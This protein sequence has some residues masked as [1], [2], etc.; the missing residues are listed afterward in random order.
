[1]C[2]YICLCTYL[3]H[4]SIHMSIHMSMRMS[5]HMS[6]H[7]SMR[8]SVHMSIHMSIHMSVHMSVHMS[9]HMCHAIAPDISEDEHCGIDLETVGRAVSITSMDTHAP[10][11]CLRTCVQ[12]REKTSQRKRLQTCAAT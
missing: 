3:L 11:P 6:M 12:T 7:M 5:V 4:M 2:P 9:M 10:R 8:M 1:M